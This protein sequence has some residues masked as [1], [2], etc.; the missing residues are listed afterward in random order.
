MANNFKENLIYLRNVKGF[1]QYELAT[2]LG[3]HA[4]TSI[5]AYECGRATPKLKTLI[6]L[7][8]IFDVSIDEL[9]LYKLSTSNKFKPPQQ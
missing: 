3:L 7:A 8:T 9:V 1:T 2:K 5:Q 6:E 4:K